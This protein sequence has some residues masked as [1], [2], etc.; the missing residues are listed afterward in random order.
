MKAILTLV[1]VGLVL[2]LAGCDSLEAQR[3]RAQAEL[4]HAQ[5]AEERARGEA[6]AQRLR[7][8]AEAAAERS[9]A[10][11]EAEA[12]LAATR[13][14]E[15]DAAHQRALETLPFVLAILGAGVVLALAVLALVRRP[16]PPTAD[17]RLLLELERLRLEAGMRERA[18]WHALASVQRQTLPAGGRAVVVYE[19]ERTERR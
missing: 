9:R 10:R 13:Q 7:A 12:S 3:L 8:Q 5:A 14:M 6:E 4:A 1:L 16:A 18:L 17:P 19:P 2:A 11:A 15:R